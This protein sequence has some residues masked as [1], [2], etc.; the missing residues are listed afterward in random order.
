MTKRSILGSSLFVVASLLAGACGNNAKPETTPITAEPEPTPTAD[1]RVLY[2]RLGGLPAITAVIKDFV[3]N[4]A[5]DPRINAQFINTDVANLE[6]K[7][8]EQVCAAT[9]GPCTYTGK[10]MR[11]VHTAMKITEDDFPA[12]VEDLVKSLDKF[13]VPEREK[14]E[15]LTALAAMH[16]DIVGI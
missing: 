7:L 3:A 4:V 9:G 10:S 5:A 13:A 1:D 11:E 12:L 16:D 8:I 14:T 6:A 15:L 2:E